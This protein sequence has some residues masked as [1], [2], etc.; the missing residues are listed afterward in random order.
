MTYRLKKI[1]KCWVKGH[2]S[3]ELGWRHLIIETVKKEL[4]K[5][6]Y[7][8]SAVSLRLDFYLFNCE[9]NDIDNLVKPVMDALKVAGLF[10]DDSAVYHL[11]TMKDN[12]PLRSD[13]GV[14]IQAW[15][16]AMGLERMGFIK[17]RRY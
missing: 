1:L 14:K 5:D 13:V 11:E 16:W 12:A 4:P 10:K 17:T 6:F 9:I 3:R 2:P 8:L 15:E 7:P